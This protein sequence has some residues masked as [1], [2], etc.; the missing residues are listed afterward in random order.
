MSESATPTPPSGP[1]PVAPTNVLADQTKRELGDWVA[2]TQYELAEKAED[3]LWRSLKSKAL[4]FSIAFLFLGFLG[5]QIMLDYVASKIKNDLQQDASSLR[6]RVVGE[7][8]DMAVETAGLKSQAETAKKELSELNQYAE[9]F[10]K[11]EPQYSAL[12]AQVDADA[13]R[14]N[15]LERELKL[16]TNQV[17]QMK[18]TLTGTQELATGAQMGLASLGTAVISSHFGGPTVISGPLTFSPA[19]TLSG[20]DFG[21]TK[22]RV[23]LFVSSSNPFSSGQ[24]FAATSLSNPSLSQSIDLGADSITSWENSSVSLSLTPQAVEKARQAAT[25]MG[26]SG[27]VN[28]QFKIQTASGQ[29]SNWYSVVGNI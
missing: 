12:K 20:F 3:R 14:V 19:L 29:E 1:N 2:R 6:Q 13:G 22:G 15:D 8:D 4:I 18:I 9:E 27:L 24:P 5:A 26:L 7:L 11:L 28:Y 21:A 25:Q 10:N 16:R 17:N 23:Y